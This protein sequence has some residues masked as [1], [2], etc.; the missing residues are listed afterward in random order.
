MPEIPW[1]NE[2][3]NDELSAGSGP[4]KSRLMTAIALIERLREDAVLD[5]EAHVQRVRNGFKSQ[6]R[7]AKRAIERLELLGEFGEYGRRSNDLGVWGPKLL[8][9]LGQGTD[10]PGEEPRWSRLL[11]AI[12][13]RLAEAWRQNIYSVEPLRPNFGLGTATAIVADLLRQAKQHGTGPSFAQALVGA[14]LEQR[15][16]IEL[17]VHAANL[18]D[19]SARARAEDRV[20]DF[21]IGDA[22][23]EVT[24]NAPDHKHR[25]QTRRVVREWKK[26]AWLLVPDDQVVSWRTALD[27]ELERDAAMAVVVGL[28]TF[29]GQN[30]AERGGFSRPATQDE[31]RELFRRYNGK[32]AEPMQA[33]Q[34]ILAG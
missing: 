31:L 30:M 2:F 14:K 13:G 34:I 17:P 20:A 25:T 16:N 33:P 24:L 8:K 1:L 19:R 3:V 28:A 12:H 11:D 10:K 22:A 26:E 18:P 29:V 9:H 15:L 7:Y 4:L 21:M 27:E 6:N 23:I 5:L 32:W